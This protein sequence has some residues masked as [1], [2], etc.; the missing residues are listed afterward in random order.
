MTTA[1]PGNATSA[2][3]SAR[4]VGA[5]EVETSDVA[6]RGGF[7]VAHFDEVETAGDFLPHRVLVIERLA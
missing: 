2:S 5:L 1:Q 7:V 6:A 3:S 4:R